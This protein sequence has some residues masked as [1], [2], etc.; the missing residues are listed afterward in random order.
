METTRPFSVT[1]RDLLI[2][3]D[4][5]TASG[6][7]KW[8]AFA[9]ELDGVHYETLRRAVAGERRPSS[10]LMEECARVLR[11]RPQYFVEYRLHLA[12]RDFDPGHAGLERAIKNLETWV[13]ARG[14]QF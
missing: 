1:L 2:E 3:H 5:V 11:I 8:S 7:P 9:V 12:Q 13:A 10:R 14:T 6:K 4:Y